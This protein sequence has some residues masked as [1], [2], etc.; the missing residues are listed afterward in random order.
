[1]KNRTDKILLAVFAVTLPL[2]IFLVLT[3]LEIIP[4]V[5]TWTLP[6]RAQELYAYLAFGFF[7][8]PVFCLQLLLCRRKRRRVA[9]IPALLIVGAA[10]LFTYG[11]FTATGWDTL[12]WG[13]LLLLCIAPAAGCTLAWIVYVLR[14]MYCRG[15]IQ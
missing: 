13:I 14:K 15:D 6:Y 12:G 10:L 2:H 4:I 7:A 9:A 5:E 11:F 8:V 3:Y 1:M